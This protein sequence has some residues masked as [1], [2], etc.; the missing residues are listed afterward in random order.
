MSNTPH[1]FVVTCAVPRGLSERL[2][3]EIAGRTVTAVG[4][5]GFRHTFELPPEVAIE[6][7]EWQVYAD[8]LELR[9]PYRNAVPGVDERDSLT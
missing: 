4:A 1:V 3:V 6:R 9:A 5:D 7:L 8:V 2:Q